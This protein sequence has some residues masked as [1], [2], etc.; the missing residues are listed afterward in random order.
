MATTSDDGPDLAVA[1]DQLTAGLCR[2]L[3]LSHDVVALATIVGET[4]LAGRRV[5][6]LMGRYEQQ[7]ASIKRVEKDRVAW[8][9]RD[10]A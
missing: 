6:K 8:R 9:L 3:A 4:D 5:E 2:Q 1:N 10:D 7:H